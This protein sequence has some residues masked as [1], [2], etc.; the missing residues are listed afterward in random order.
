MRRTPNCTRLLAVSLLAASPVI[1]SCSLVMAGTDD[2][3]TMSAQVAAANDA[4][5]TAALALQKEYSAHHDAQSSATA[6]PLRAKCDFFTENSNP[7]VTP[8]AIV[9][10]LHRSYGSTASSVYV[11]WQ[12][13]SGIKGTVDK[14]LV[15]QLAQ[16]YESAPIG[17]MRPGLDPDQKIHFTQAVAQLPEGDAAQINAAFDKQVKA[18]DELSKPFAE[19]RDDLAKRLPVSFGLAR[20]EFRD[21]VQR[22]SYGMDGAEMMAT[23]ISTGKN[24]AFDPDATAEQLRQ[25]AG[26]V[27]S[28]LREMGDRTA[29]IGDLSPATGLIRSVAYARPRGEAER[30]TAER[31]TQNDRDAA[32]FPPKF[33]TE[34]FWD[35]KIK[36]LEWKTGSAKFSSTAE[37]LTFR[38]MLIDQAS[39]VES[40]KA[41]G[42]ASAN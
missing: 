20:T 38:R 25:L 15:S 6:P 39:Q 37:L 26:D 30:G 31:G 19:Y 4:V 34:V 36:G 42:T 13:L 2:G 32:M 5:K 17:T 1:A 24:W 11:H 21:A 33:F 9:D 22:A 16:V 41:K 40:A 7:A 12:L 27:G 18:W 23:A 14:V 35:P 3:K 29:A 8:K 10:A 28:L